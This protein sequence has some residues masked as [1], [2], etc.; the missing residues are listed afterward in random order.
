MKKFATILTAALVISVYSTTV[1]SAS[2]TN[3]NHMHGSHH[4]D[5]HNNGICDNYDTHTNGCNN[6]S[7]HCEGYVDA[8]GDGICDNTK[9]TIKYNLN[10]GKNNKKNPSCYY[11]T[12]KTIKL[13]KPTKKGYTF[14]G[15]YTDKQCEDKVTSIKKGSCGKKTLYAKWEKNNIQSGTVDCNTK[16]E[17]MLCG[18]NMR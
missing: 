17:G 1:I 18:A 5:S 2:H 3:G 6:H 11:V 12:T 8:N 13:K 4:V 9:Y 14:K 10:G 7:G 16:N 15:W